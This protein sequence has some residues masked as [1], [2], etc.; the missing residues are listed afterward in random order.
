MI[1]SRRRCCAGSV[2]WYSSTVTCAHRRRT[3]SGHIVVLLDELSGDLQQV[4]EVDL[5]RCGLCR[6][7]QLPTARH[8]GWPEASPPPRTLGRL[9][10]ALRA[11]QLAPRPG[12]LLFHVAL[13]RRVRLPVQGP[14]NYVT[15][16]VPLVA[17]R[18]HVGDR[19]CPAGQGPVV[20]RHTQPGGVEGPGI[21]TLYLQLREP[22]PSS[23]AAFL[24]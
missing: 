14:P 7:E 6:V 9:G 17:L 5:P 10:V 12:D 13:R 18:E 2:S 20:P 24:E 11:Q 3:A 19:L 8:R 23:A 22:F 16:E 1:A 21:D 4:S 15:P